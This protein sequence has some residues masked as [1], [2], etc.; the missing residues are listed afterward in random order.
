M[1][2]VVIAG[3]AGFLGSSLAAALM[4]RPGIRPIVLDTNPRRLR[5]ASWLKGVTTRELNFPSKS[6][7]SDCLTEADVLV[8]LAS[9]SRPGSNTGGF[10]QEVQ[11]NVVGSIR[12]FEA[13][14][15][16]G[17]KRVVF[18]SSGGTV[19][20]RPTS[21]PI[22]EDH[23]TRPICTYGACK[24]AIER[25]LGVM[26]ALSP[27]VL[28]IGNPYGP[29]QLQGTPVGAIASFVRAHHSERSVEV[30]GDG[31]VV[32]DY[33]HIDD[34]VRAFEHS[35]DQ[36]TPPGTYNIA[37]GLGRSLMEILNVIGDISGRKPEVCFKNGRP[38]DVDR[39]V[40]DV[41]RFRRICGWEEHMTL[42]QG[43]MQLWD[44]LETPSEQELA[45]Q[46]V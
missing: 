15:N 22:S 7:L 1:K 14:L 38:F 3:G 43:V 46:K 39:V 21:L 20:G 4:E 27:V 30:W 9:T 26:T 10:E 11:D 34:V 13:A 6:G 29:Y 31:C 24:V 19:Y 36:Q 40:L 12:L 42:Q 16:A 35:I 17:V 25:L 41:S 2:N 28:R 45:D 18:A 23:R 8:H 5:S 37:S 44:Y 32:R 33:V